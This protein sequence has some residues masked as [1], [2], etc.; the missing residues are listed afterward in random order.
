[1]CLNSEVVDEL[2]A[3]TSAMKDAQEQ[4]EQWLRQHGQAEETPLQVTRAEAEQIFAQRIAAHESRL[5]ELGWSRKVR[6]SGESQLQGET[7]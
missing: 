2:H 7:K 6:V 4:R 3:V 1:M 5:A